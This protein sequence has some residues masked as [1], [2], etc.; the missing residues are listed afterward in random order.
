M[1]DPGYL[2]CSGNIGADAIDQQ[3]ITIPISAETSDVGEV[4]DGSDLERLEYLQNLGADALGLLG[5]GSA[6]NVWYCDSGEGT[7]TE[8]GVSWATATDTLKEAID[9]CTDNAGDVILVAAGHVENIGASVAIDSPGITIIGLG[10]GAHRPILTFNA[11]GGVLAHTVPNVKYKNII[12]VC[13]TQDTTSAITLDASSDSAIIEDCVF[14][15]TTTSEFIDTVTL[16]GACDYV[17][18]TRC[19]FLNN[20]A[21]GGNISCINS[22]AGVTNNLIIEDCEFYG[23]F[24]TAAIESTQIEVDCQIVNNTIYNTSTGD[25]AIKM[26]AAALGTLSGNFCY[27]DTYG[28]IIDPGSLQCRNNYV[29][30]EIDESGYLWPP[31]REHIDSVHGTGR[32]IYVDSGATAGGGGTWETA[33]NTIDAAMDD[34]V[35]DRGDTIYVAQGHVEVEAGAASIF[36]ADVEGVS[37]IGVSNGAASGAIAAGAVTGT[38]SQMP[39]FILD[40]ASATATV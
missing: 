29:S 17:R 2:K 12:F 24:T 6:G 35:A 25:Y 22:T 31:Q 37:I 3:G 11:L 40:H 33:F 26:S 16:A 8:D 36:T 18:F 39:V 13:S 21:A 28:T 4:A 1:L 10:V 7:G 5:A 34:C 19:K 27:G 14:R 38:D 20:T 15:N 30:H 23:A 32:V 9:L